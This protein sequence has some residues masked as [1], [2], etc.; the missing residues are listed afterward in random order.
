MAEAE[1]E[2][3]PDDVLA[4][5][6]GFISSFTDLAQASGVCKKWK[7][8]VDQSMGRRRSLIFAGWK[9]DDEST[10]RI[11]GLA[12]SL[13][14]LDI[15]KSRWGCQITDEGLAKI[16]MAKCVGNLTSVSLWGMSGITDAGV[17]QL[18]SRAGSLQHLNI[19]GTFVTDES[20][21]A[22]AHNCPNLKS[23]V[24]WACRHIT[25]S[26]MLVLVTQCR[27]LEA[28]N[29]WGTRVAVAGLLAVSPDLQ[30]KKPLNLGAHPLLQVA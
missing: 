10:A 6:L 27:K 26:G 7:R 21:Y 20:L 17:T 11:V 3:L 1:I 30:I 13:R 28:I 29:L 5:V 4:H 9:M 16:S 15:S 8:G 2:R 25:E 24:L 18:I 23:I 14:E 12:Y 22:I 19:G